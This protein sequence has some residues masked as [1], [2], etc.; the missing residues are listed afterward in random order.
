MLQHV[1]AA[2]AAR[3]P[4]TSCFHLKEFSRMPT[5]IGKRQ[6]EEDDPDSIVNLEE[7]RA[8]VSG[9]NTWQLSP[10]QQTGQEGIQKPQWLD[11]L[12]SNDGVPHWLQAVKDALEIAKIHGALIELEKWVP[13]AGLAMVQIYFPSS[14]RYHD[15]SI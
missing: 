10:G 14:I 2:G 11:T 8:D 13:T 6:K 4:S 5:I 3:V 12:E 1:H 7:A 9:L 15:E